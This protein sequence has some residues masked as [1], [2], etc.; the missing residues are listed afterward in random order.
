M[1]V[2][3]YY[4]D[5][6][7]KT[8][9][10]HH[11]SSSMAPMAPPPAFDLRSQ[12][13]ENC[14]F[15]SRQD[16]DIS[17]VTALEPLGKFKVLV[18]RAEQGE[19]EVLM[20][21]HAPSLQEAIHG[22]HVKSA[23]AVQNYISTNG[24]VF[25]TSLKK[26][27]SL[28]PSS[29]DS[30]DGSDSDTASVSSTVTVDQSPSTTYKEESFSDNETVSVTSTG[31]LKKCARGKPARIPNPYTQAAPKSQP[32]RRSRSRS[33]SPARSR[34]RSRSSDESSENELDSDVPTVVP[35]VNRRPPFFNGNGFSQRVR[36]VPP[37][38][39]QP[40][41]A[42]PP[43]PPPPGPPN[44]Q[45]GP[46]LGWVMGHPHS[47][48]TP[49]PSAVPTTKPNAPPRPN[50]TNS[51]PHRPSGPPQH[52][53]LLHIHWRHHGEQRTLEQAPFSVRSLQDTAIAYVRRSP[54][55]FSNVT[56]ADKSPARLWH[57]RATVVSVQ[58]DG[59]DYDLSN[60]PGD[61]L[62]R[63]ISALGPKGVVRFEV[64][65]VSM[66]G[67]GNQ[68]QQQGQG[69]G[70]NLPGI[71]AVMGGGKNG[72]GNGGMNMCSWPMPMG[73]GMP[74]PMPGGMPVM[75]MGAAAPA[76]PPPPPPPPSAG[77]GQREE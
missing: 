1:L 61:D 75:H 30:E 31:L 10:R 9:T 39:F 68:G 51:T 21:E 3:S 48:I 56:T 49:P 58:V 25:A 35:L 4:F 76:P 24:Y 73:M 8:P 60:Y 17:L 63:F 5:S 46:P 28:K 52:D 62:T 7:Q 38:G 15:F 45:A 57:L 23:A 65:V 26:K 67:E 36:C 27:R 54:A 43:P 77:T 12:V 6:A 32:A 19:R 41:M 16:A 37:R 40:M 72:N 42:P 66:G 14:K 69:Q 33:R 2:P 22:L 53:I 59:E 44:P 55:S 50:G 34:S 20:S 29:D 74:M 71:R 13:I 11:L 64:E 18:L 47:Y 70:G